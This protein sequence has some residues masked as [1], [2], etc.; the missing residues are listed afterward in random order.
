[1][2]RKRTIEELSGIVCDLR[3]EADRVELEMRRRQAHETPDVLRR[4]GMYEP[5]IKR[6]MADDE[7]YQL[8]DWIDAMVGVGT[9]P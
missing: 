2:G 7:E 1:M 6:L 5:Q 8:P 9:K 3:D 4:N